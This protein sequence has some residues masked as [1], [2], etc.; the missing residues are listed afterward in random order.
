MNLTTKTD[1][2]FP[3]SSDPH[4]YWTGYFTSRPALK[5]M[6]REGNNFLQVCKQQAALTK[7]QRPSGDEA[8]EEK[9]T[10]M[11]EVMGVLQHH[12]AV[13]GTAKQAV[14]FD[15]AQR[16]AKGFK[17]CQDVVDKTMG[18]L[19]GK[20]Q[21]LLP[22]QRYCQ[23]L[24]VSWCGIS[25]NYTTFVT[26]VYN[27]LTRPVVKFVR[28]PIRDPG[29]EVFAPNGDSILTQVVPVSEKLKLVPGR[30][31]LAKY[32]LVFQANLPALGFKSYY[33]TRNAKMAKKQMSEE[34]KI[35]KKTVMSNKAVTVGI[36]PKGNVK[37]IQVGGKV[38]NLAQNFG[39]YESHPGENQ[40]FDDRASGAY[41]FRP[42]KQSPTPI[43]SKS[44]AK[45][46]KGPLVQ[47]VHQDCSPF[48]SQV[49][50]L[51]GNDSNLEFDF[52]VGPIP[53]KDSKG[54]E[55]VTMYTTDLKS[56]H[57]CPDG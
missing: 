15:Y 55:I 41:I 27:P 3:Y 52:V 7:H 35:G 56:A 47:E 20:P 57:D 28:L 30:K 38:I 48:C 5:G 11:R 40:G 14:T 23:Y 53:V 26:Q 4:A 17:A 21:E 6:V 32:E 13:S 18:Y 42:V 31:S 45:M 36:G 44:A 54:K 50:R 29:F 12:D 39:Y 19:A 1:D 22:E 24:N 10:T 16:L 8:T 2:F 46:F 33:V 37:K 43:P 34:V 49:I 51:Y 25:E 9:V